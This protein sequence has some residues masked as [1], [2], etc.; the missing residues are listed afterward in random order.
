MGTVAIQQ[1]GEWYRIEI[2][3][4]ST[5][6]RLAITPAPLGISD[7]WEGEQG[8]L[9]VL[10]FPRGFGRGMSAYVFTL[11][12]LMA[13][14]LMV[15]SRLA[16]PADDMPTFVKAWSSEVTAMLETLIHPA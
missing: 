4:E 3:A 1:F 11:D 13:D 15:A 7:L 5:P 8:Y 12:Q 10:L 16:I 6:F 9:L 14:G 2:L